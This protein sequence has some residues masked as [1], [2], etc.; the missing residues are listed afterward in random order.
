MKNMLLVKK[1]E[2]EAILFIIVG[3]AIGYLLLLHM[4]TSNAHALSENG[5]QFPA[6][7]LI[8][9]STPP[10]AVPTQTPTPTPTPA[11]LI[12]SAPAAYIPSVST[13]SQIS[14]DGTQTVTLRTIQNKDSTETFDITS[15]DS[16]TFMFSKTLP[17]G[18]S[19]SIPYNTWSPDDK[20]FF[21][22]ENDGSQT[23]VMVFNDNGDPFANG[24]SYLDLTGD[25]AKYAPGAIFDE[26][27]GWAAD[28][29]IIILTKN[30]DGSEGTSYWYGVPDESVTPLATKF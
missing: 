25:F 24:D 12:T 28:N 19:I 10:S 7:A 3:A 16:S 30:A 11:P 26:A 13:T 4:Q 29:L 23:A 15:S 14:S 22:Q 20:Y 2:I 18:Q 17:Q 1:L 6:V 5:Q 8:P 27:S 21:I 9:S